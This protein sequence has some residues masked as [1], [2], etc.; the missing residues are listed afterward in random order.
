MVA[1]ARRDYVLAFWGE[2]SDEWWC[3]EAPMATTT[4]TTKKNPKRTE[5]DILKQI[6]ALAE[7][8]KPTDRRTAVQILCTLQ[9]AEDRRNGKE[10]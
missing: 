5:L 1:V 6:R 7:E 4:Q 3:K 8:L 10:W 2:L 9:D